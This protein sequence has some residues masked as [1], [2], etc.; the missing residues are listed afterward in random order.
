M[1][2]GIRLVVAAVACLV[3]LPTI[4]VNAAQA[5]PPAPK[6]GACYAYTWKALNGDHGPTKT[7]SC[8][9]PHTAVTY[10]VGTFTGAAATSP[11][12]LNPA[13]VAD[14]GSGCWAA[15]VRK[16]GVKAAALTRVRMAYFVPTQAQWDAG[17]RW[18]RCDAT[19]AKSG[20]KVAPIPKNFLRSAKKAAGISA[21]R[22][23]LTVQGKLVA[24]TSGKA[25]FVARANATL[26]SASSPYPGDGVV[27]LSSMQRCSRALGK[28]FKY[29]TWPLADGWALGQRQA[30]CYV[31][32]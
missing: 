12:P 16:V 28:A 25:H 9:K 7:V 32:M 24:C 27:Y 11:T 1:N 14:S 3:S 22:R 6:V 21:Y 15:F 20:T 8:S 30:T 19:L 5:A 29:A 10:Y 26:G 17:A 2:R 23:C 18:Y 31:R 13:A 4:G